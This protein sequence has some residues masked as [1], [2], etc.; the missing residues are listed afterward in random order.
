M[1]ESAIFTWKKASNTWEE[2]ISFGK[3]KFYKC[4]K[5]YIIFMPRLYKWKE[6]DEVPNGVP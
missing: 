1:I 5:V 4:K 2:S 6:T 3:I